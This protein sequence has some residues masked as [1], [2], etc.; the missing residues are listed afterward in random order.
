MSSVPSYRYEPLQSGEIRLL[1][2]LPRNQHIEHEPI[3]F[4]IVHTSLSRCQSADS[5]F[6]YEALSYVWGGY[7]AVPVYCDDR[8]I[9]VT[10]NL[11][12]ALFRLRECMP[13]YPSFH[14]TLWVDAICINQNDVVERGHQV[15]LMRDIFSRAKRVVVWLGSSRQV[16]DCLMQIK[17]GSMTP[18]DIDPILQA[19]YI[20]EWG[21]SVA[22]IFDQ[23]WFQRVWVIQ[24][25]VFA[26][27]VIVLGVT[28][29]IK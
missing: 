25:V 21:M 29:S 14:R 15:R 4:H 19:R 10:P 2:L 6:A 12:S 27:K 13:K 18:K 5:F 9:L 24:E 22:R 3:R 26:A 17:K 7:R 11:L 23:P 8:E 16:E 1:Q 20:A 28:A